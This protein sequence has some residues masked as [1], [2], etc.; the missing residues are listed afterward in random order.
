[1]R[2][3]YTEEPEPVLPTPAPVTIQTSLMTSRENTHG[4]TEASGA[5]VASVAAA[6]SLSASHSE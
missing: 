3:D 1:M 5:D 4:I 6:V 2:S